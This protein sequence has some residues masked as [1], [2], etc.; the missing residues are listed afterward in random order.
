M[1]KADGN[2]LG[3]LSQDYSSEV[4]VLRGKCQCSLWLVQDAL[5]MAL[6]MVLSMPLADIMAFRKVRSAEEGWQPP[7]TVQH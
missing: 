3:A 4:K 5:E 1:Q 6:Q 7:L 2:T